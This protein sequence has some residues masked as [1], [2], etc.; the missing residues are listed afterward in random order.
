MRVCFFVVAA[1]AALAW[2]EETEE[3]VEE[4]EAS[5]S[6]ETKVVALTDAT[7]ERETMASI[8]ALTGDWLVT[9]CLGPCQATEEL[10]ALARRF[11]GD[12]EIHVATVD[13]ED[14]LILAKRFSVVEAG[15]TLFFSKGFMWDYEGP[16]AVDTLAAFLN[17]TDRGEG[18]K[19][20][21]K[22]GPLKPIHEA[23]GNFFD[24]VDYRLL[25]IALCSLSVLLI[26]VGAFMPH[27]EVDGDDSDKPKDDKTD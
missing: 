18:I 3:P 20:P 13:A 25:S 27:P 19:V 10:E 9:F 7:F 22:D 16:T 24:V 1:C 4:T 6:N 15:R 17:A 8:G 12:E 14:N 5:T 2:A 11:E 26:L 23:L 21:R